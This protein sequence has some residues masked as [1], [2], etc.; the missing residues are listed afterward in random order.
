MKKKNPKRSSKEK[1]TPTLWGLW[2]KHYRAEK[3]MTAEQLA[4][5]LGLNSASVYHWECGR[6][7]PTIHHLVE[8]A[9]V[10]KVEPQRFFDKKAS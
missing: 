6:A 5:K 4:E 9:K 8:I 3:G 10:F 2:I 1:L 7:S